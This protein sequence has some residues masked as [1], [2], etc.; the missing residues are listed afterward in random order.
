VFEVLFWEE[1]LS[2]VEIQEGLLL[3]E[4]ETLLL[5]VLLVPI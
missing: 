5:E 4:V 1:R 2:M 3:V